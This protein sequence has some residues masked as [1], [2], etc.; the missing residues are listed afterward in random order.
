M[1]PWKIFWAP[2]FYFPWSGDV[3]QR[4]APNTEWFT[5]LIKPEAGDPQIEEKAFGV[6]SY[7]KQL[8]IIAEILLDLADQVEPKTDEA[9][10]ALGQLKKISSEINAI[11]NSVNR[12]ILDEL[13]S[14]IST[15]KKRNPEKYREF[16]QRL[17]AL[18]QD[19]SY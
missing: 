3:A 18:S 6:A 15:L 14:N 9:K 19:Q 1:Y 2:Q 16:Q 5:D 12:D 8:G 7:G 17:D 4:I 10:R 11:K 13:I